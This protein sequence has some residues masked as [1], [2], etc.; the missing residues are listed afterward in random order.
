MDVYIAFT[1]KQQ[2]KINEWKDTLPKVK[3]KRTY[4]ITFISMDERDTNGHQVFKAI[5]R[6]S[7]GHKL[8]VTKKA[9]FH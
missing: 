4:G 5:M 8:L 2:I 9:A 7:D 3:G 6:S 1:Q